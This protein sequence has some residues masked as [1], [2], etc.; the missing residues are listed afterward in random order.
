ML[1]LAVISANFELP[2]NF[3]FSS[4]KSL[5]GFPNNSASKLNSPSN[6]LVSFLNRSGLY[7]CTTFL[8]LEDFNLISIDILGFLVAFFTVPSIYPLR[9]PRDAS[10]SVFRLSSGNLSI[11]P[12]SLKGN[13]LKSPARAMVLLSSTL[14]A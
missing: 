14:G 8:R 7:F 3:I 2:E 4:L 10:I 9:L 5:L 6:R 13:P 1:P 12:L 11:E